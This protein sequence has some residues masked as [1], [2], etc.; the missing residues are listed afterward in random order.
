MIK[1]RIIFKYEKENTVE[2]R[3]NNINQILSDVNC[4]ESD[5]EIRKPISGEI[6]LIE[7]EEYKVVN[8]K[9]SFEKIDDTV[10]YDFI[11]L[12]KRNIEYKPVDKEKEDKYSEML[13]RLVEQRAKE[14]EKKNKY[15]QYDH[16]LGKYDKY[17]HYEDDDRFS[18]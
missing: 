18:F 7:E 17:R 5:V 13:K 11:V 6:I 4:I 10:Y 14:I 12:L 16:Y 8:V 15:V 3:S 9:L 2:D 1:Y